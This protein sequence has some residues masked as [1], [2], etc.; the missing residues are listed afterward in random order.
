[1]YNDLNFQTTE[2]NEL[3]KNVFGGELRYSFSSKKF[4]TTL[5]FNNGQQYLNT[6]Y[7]GRS[8]LGIN[9]FYKINEKSN[10][11]INI[12]GNYTNPRKYSLPLNTPSPFR[13]FLK[14]QVIYGYSISPL[15]YIFGGTGYEFIST[16]A[17]PAL[18]RGVDVF[19]TQTGFL[20]VGIR[21]RGKKSNSVMILQVTSGLVN[22]AKGPTTIWENT[23]PAHENPFVNYNILS[24]SLR[25][26]KWG[27]QAMYS[28][29]PRSIQ[30]QFGW[31]FQD[32]NSR[33][34]QVMPYY[35]S[36]IYKRSIYL[37]VGISYNNDLVAIS[38][39]T[40]LNTQIEWYLPNDWKIRA[41][42]V[43]SV[44]A[45]SRSAGDVERY[46]TVYMEAGVRKEFGIQQQRQK[47]YDLKVVFFKD[48]NGNG[49]KEENEPGINNVLFYIERVDEGASTY[50]GFSSSELLSNQYGEVVLTRIPSGVYETSYNPVGNDAGTF[51]K[52]IDALSINL[53]K[54]KTVY[55]P[56]VEKNKVY[57]KI[58]LNRSRLSGIGR[59]D[60]SNVRITATDSQGRSYSSLTDT[61]GNILL[62]APLFYDYILSFITIF[63]S[64]FNLRQNT[65][66]I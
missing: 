53:E 45:R 15:F 55:V 52:G 20:N 28:I 23:I 38:S 57:G 62:F 51:S 1:L 37:D 14:N 27:F 43:Y 66:L 7:N 12:N 30:D 33:Y 54:S 63:Y 2:N 42:N 3:S 34:L 31:Y 60:L 21:L 29:G 26:L 8:V 18:E 47:F 11:G 24:L 56:F 44:Q 13:S 65:F 9:S 22:I 10:I 48:Y 4:R 6:G 58:V 61:E 39:Y 35:R 16:D 17:F 19:S 49:V 41:L 46:Q 59:I 40:N 50:Q 25:R 5:R 64:I 32:I 36:F